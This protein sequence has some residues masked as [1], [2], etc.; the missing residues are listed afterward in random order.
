MSEVNN[1]LKWSGTRIVSALILALILLGGVAYGI[2]S[3]VNGSGTSTKPLSQ[4]HISAPRSNNR[5]RSSNNNVSTKANSNASKSSGSVASGANNNSH[6]TNTGP[7]QTAFYGFI[8]AVILG[9]FL[10]YGW[11]KH[12]SEK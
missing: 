5:S 12:Q 8:A 3:V 1:N 6:L 2:F 11:I 9:Y 10:R 7:G 4:S